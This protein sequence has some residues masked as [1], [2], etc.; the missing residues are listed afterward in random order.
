MM[1]NAIQKAGPLAMRARLDKQVFVQQ[2]KSIKLAESGLVSLPREGSRIGIE[3]YIVRW[4][5][6]TT[7]AGVDRSG[8]RWYGHKRVRRRSFRRV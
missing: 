1:L 3:R 6:G 7:H 5:R 4:G 2:A 8:L